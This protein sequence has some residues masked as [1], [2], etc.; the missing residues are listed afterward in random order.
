MNFLRAIL[1]SI[2]LRWQAW[3]DRVEA[4]L[5]DPET[6][7]WQRLWA[8]LAGFFV[9]LLSWE[10]P[11]LP[12]P[13]YL[14]VA[15]W[16]QT[17]PYRL[18]WSAL[19]ALLASLALTATGTLCLVA[20]WPGRTPDYYLTVARRA[21]VEKDYETAR[22]AS[23]RLLQAGAN[24]QLALFFL[25]MSFDGLGRKQDAAAV[26][27]AVA[28]P[29][30][31]V[32][33]PAHLYAAKSLLN[34]TNLT[35]PD[36]LLAETHLKHVLAID[37]AC[38]EADD[39]LGRLYA[40]TQRW[41]PAKQHLSTAAA[42][43]PYAGVTLAALLA[44]LGEF[45]RARECAAA[46]ENR[47]RKLAGQDAGPGLRLAWAKAK[48]LQD[49]FPAAIALLQAGRG[50]LSE[51]A[52]AA[53]MGEIYCLWAQ[54]TARTR[55]DD[56]PAHVTLL[57]KGLAFAPKDPRL[58]KLLADLSA[59]SEA[60]A[61]P[62]RQTMQQLLAQGHAPDLLHFL[63]GS[64]AWAKGDTAL[65]RQHF[66][67][68]YENSPNAALVANN[69]AYLLAVGEPPDLPRALNIIN[70]LIEQYPDNPHYRDTR[71]QIFARLG[72]WREA[73]ADLES[74]L[75]RLT[76]KGQTHAA[77]AAAYRGLGMAQLAAEHERLARPT[78]PQNPSSP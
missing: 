59:R 43:S 15:A 38:T 5:Q 49:D 33:A 57:Q 53:A 29:G 20:R 27:S 56:L 67:L 23:Q 66:Q 30:Q 36:L 54:Q 46:A 16:F 52:Y 37:P 75:P 7:A 60:A 9:A 22:V 21:L 62:A 10:T 18:L 41:E 8:R 58:L 14:P 11:A 51:S 2:Q 73:V 17:R 19:P 76:Q 68:A 6:S 71:G 12:Q 26:L 4:A 65:A 24:K 42:S 32:Y 78:Q 40:R 72:R 28:P 55:P 48:A 31:P 70:P 77:L 63:L 64:A 39:I 47:F 35:T 1:S 61:E 25:A 74:A 45:D 13:L 3:Q 44:D 34:H 50:S 69:L